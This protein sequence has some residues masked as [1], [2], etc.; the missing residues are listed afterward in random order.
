MK[1]IGAWQRLNLWPRLVIGVTFVFLVLFG[2]F[3]LI[4]LRAVSDSTD[5]ILQERLVIAQM[6]ARE[7]DRLV[8]R[9]FYELEKATEFASFDPRALC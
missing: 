8:E 9:G 1:L 7:I 5:R 6:A 4:S 2:I 3:S